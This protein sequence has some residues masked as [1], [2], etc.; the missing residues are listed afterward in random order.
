MVQAWGRLAT[1]KSECTKN[2]QGDRQHKKLFA[3]SKVFD[4]ALVLL[5][6][7]KLNQSCKTYIYISVYT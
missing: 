3:M 6:C 2:I 1:E 4:T 5:V 7:E